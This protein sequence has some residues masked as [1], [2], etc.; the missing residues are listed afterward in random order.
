MVSEI[1]VSPLLLVI[2]F[3]WTWNVA[4]HHGTRVWW[5]EAAYLMAP[6]KWREEEAFEA[7][8]PVTYFLQPGLP[9]NS[10]SCCTL[11]TALNP[12]HPVAS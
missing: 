2:L 5:R 4:E 9:P 10:P 3:L 7:E 12:H 1:S 6:G 11:V 8:S